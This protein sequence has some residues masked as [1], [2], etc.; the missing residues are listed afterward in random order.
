ME[1]TTIVSA[2]YNIQRE[3]KGDGRKWEDYLQWFRDT[4]QF[5]HP[6]VIFVPSELQDFVIQHRPKKYKTHL[7]LQELHEVPYAFL[8]P[9]A[10]DI[11]ESDEYK[12]K[13]THPERVECKVPFYNLIQYSKFQ[14]LKIASALNPFDTEYFFWMDAGISRFLPNIPQKQF[15]SRLSFPKKKLVIQ[16]N[17]VYYHYHVDE[18]YLWDSQCLLSGGILG[19]DKEV[20][21]ELT[22]IIHKELL[23]RVENKWIN[24]EQLLLAYIERKRKDLFSLVFNNT[25][26]P[27]CLLDKLFVSSTSTRA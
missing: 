2:L 26:A 9:K 27:I 14:W 10:R 15:H 20:I 4:L 13:I 18:N 24:N 22:D 7:V 1:N 6:M 8:E 25:S 21:H 19:G 17:H 16:N 5:P 11:L 3:T 12:K 23:D